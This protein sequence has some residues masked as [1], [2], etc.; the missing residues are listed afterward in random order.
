MPYLSRNH[1]TVFLIDAYA[2][3]GRAIVSPALQG[4]DLARQLNASVAFCTMNK[5]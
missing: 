1:S 3:F 5:F 4:S 2:V